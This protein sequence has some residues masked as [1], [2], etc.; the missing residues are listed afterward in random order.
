VA[1][2]RNAGY[3]SLGSSNI[4]IGYE[5]GYN[6]T[7]SNR[8][9]VDNTSTTSPLIGGQ[10]ENNRIGINTLVSDIAR[11]LHVTGEVRITDLITDTATKLVGA[12]NDGDL[13]GITVTG[14]GFDG[15]TLTGVGGSGVA[16]RIPFWSDT[17][18]LSSTG[19]LYWNNV[20]NY[21]QLKGIDK[22]L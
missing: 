12:D 9:Y 17:Y 15:S 16:T 6:E 2:G 22:I 5:A 1:I 14:L 4:Y 13:S 8:L 19:N 10:F 21:L 11:S 18:T 3:A 20:S 7:G